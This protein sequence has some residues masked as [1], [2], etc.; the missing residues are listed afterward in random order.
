MKANTMR[1]PLLKAGA[2]LL[3]FVLLAYLTSASPEGGVLDS[4]GLIIIG[5]F[6][7]VQWAIAMIIGVTVCIAVLIGIF[8]FAVSLYDREA[9]SELYAKTKASVAELLAP[10]FAFVDSLRTQ[11]R[12]DAPAAAASPA[13]QPLIAEPTPAPA[14]PA[15]DTAKLQDELQ[16]LITG[17]IRKVAD[18]QQSLHDQF[19][20]L[21]AKLGNIEEKAAGFAAAD[22]VSAVAEE[23]AAT[24]KRLDAVQAAV[25]SLEGRIDD[26]GRKL[27]D[28][29]PDKILGDL[30]GRLAQIE[31]QGEAPVFDPQPLTESIQTL[32]K[33]ME[34]LKKKG[35]GGKARKKA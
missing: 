34:E 11:G 23:I 22:Q 32:Q 3:V 14:A 30:P 27:Q 8:L 2:V 1:A 18:S 15:V 33:E 26:T 13:V 9:S 19:A 20:V 21:H 12:T 24:G 25:A 28:L 10:V 16:T 35:S 4:L 7:L 6:R 31:Q 5:A 29:T 17:E